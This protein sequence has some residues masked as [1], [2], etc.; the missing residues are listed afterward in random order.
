[1]L[2]KNHLLCLCLSLISPHESFPPAVS[3]F[4][5][6]LYHN[7]VYNCSRHLHLNLVTVIRVVSISADFMSVFGPSDKESSVHLGVKSIGYFII[8]DMSYCTSPQ[9]VTTFGQVHHRWYKMPQCSLLYQSVVGTPVV[10]YANYTEVLYHQYHIFKV[11]SFIYVETD[12][13]GLV[14]QTVPQSYSSIGCLMSV[15][16]VLFK[17]LIEPAVIFNNFA[18]S[19]GPFSETH[20]VWPRF[21]RPVSGWVACFNKL[22]PFR[23]GSVMLLL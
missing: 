16:H 3:M 19:T 22:L 6:F 15:S 2:H 5:M 13:V 9:K 14:N 20:I 12:C 18:I 10:K 17:P 4:Q 11:F 7:A 21:S 23:W 8:G 1:M